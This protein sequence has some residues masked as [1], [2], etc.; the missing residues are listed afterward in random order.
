M[1]RDQSALLAM[2]RRTDYLEIHLLDPLDSP[3]PP[4]LTF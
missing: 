2:K 3:V 4:L 1:L